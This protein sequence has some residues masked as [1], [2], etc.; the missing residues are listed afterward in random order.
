[1]YHYFSEIAWSYNV[2]KGKGFKFE[3]CLKHA[4]TWGHHFNMDISKKITR[5][6][7]HSK[8]S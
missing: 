3:D 4:A 1:M 8:I 5:F 6:T 7:E 2:K